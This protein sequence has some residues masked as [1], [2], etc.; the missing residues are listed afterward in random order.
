MCSEPSGELNRAAE[1]AAKTLMEVQVQTSEYRSHLY[2]KKSL[3]TLAKEHAIATKKLKEAIELAK[4]RKE[5]IAEHDIKLLKMC[6]D[7]VRE[8]GTLVN[9]SE[10][11]EIVLPKE[12]P[13]RDRGLD[14]GSVLFELFSRSPSFVKFNQ[15][16]DRLKKDP[17]WRDKVAEEVEKL[18]DREVL[19]LAF[20]K[21]VDLRGY[22]R[23][24]MQQIMMSVKER[25]DRMDFPDLSKHLTQVIGNL[26]T[27]IIEGKLTQLGSGAVNKVYRV[28]YLD[29][30]GRTVEGVFKPDPS[31]LDAKTRFKEQFFGT[32]AASGI[33]PGMDAHLPSRAVASSVVDRLLYGEETISVRTRFAI[34]NGQRGI[35]MEKAAGKSPVAKKMERET[36]SFTENPQ[37]LE[38]VETQIIEKNKGKYNAND[39]KF[40]GAMTYCRDVRIEGDLAGKWWLT[41]IPTSFEHFSPD[42]ATTAEGLLKLQVK[43]FINGECDR[44]PQNYFIDDRGRV[45]GIDEDCCFGVNAVPEDIDVRGQKTLR[46]IIPNNASL[47]LRMPPVVTKEI[48]R[49]INELYDNREMLVH[50]L[51]P[52]ISEDEIR[53]TERRLEMLKNHVNSD[54]CLVVDDAEG[55]LSPE[56]KERIDT[57]NSYWARELFVYSSDIKGWNYLR[58]HRTI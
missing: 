4:S 16:A 21:E 32:A 52:F 31:G 6:I 24:V 3:P 10:F 7:K 56:A 43:D 36:I 57:N 27:I 2:S 44:H 18:T 30:Q 5:E 12:A 8:L 35:L 53:A 58:S 17:G 28:S 13:L 15:N 45:T 55:L 19:K 20:S 41:G 54:S 9:Y 29:E 23:E 22:D 38:F 11:V 51:G 39:L 37:V 48:Q 47:M 40:I 42:N 34:V 25:I 46:G 33:P 50:S 1:G 26:E 49:E 14:K